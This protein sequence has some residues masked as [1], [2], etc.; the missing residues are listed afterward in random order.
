MRFARPTDMEPGMWFRAHGGAE[1]MRWL[2][3]DRVVSRFPGRSRVR[4]L[5]DV[6]FV[7]N[8]DARFQVIDFDGGK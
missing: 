3:V 5:C 1:P 6:P 7:C 2:G 8:A 4:V